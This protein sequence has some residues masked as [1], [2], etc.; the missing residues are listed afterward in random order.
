M[1][2]I[3]MCNPQKPNLLWHSKFTNLI[4]ITGKGGEVVGGFSMLGI[5]EIFA[6]WITNYCC[7]PPSLFF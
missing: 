1:K 3:T 4:S 6:A 2:L 7:F 5:K